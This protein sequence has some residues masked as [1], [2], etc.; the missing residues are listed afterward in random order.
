MLNSVPIGLICPYC[1]LLFFARNEGVFY[2]CPDC[3]RR[4]KAGVNEMLTATLG[5]D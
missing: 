1:G 2:C 5:D 4:W 3:S